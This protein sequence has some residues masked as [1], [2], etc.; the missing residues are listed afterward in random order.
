M[1]HGP[2]TGEYF[3][4]LHGKGV[5]YNWE[6]LTPVK[7]GR[8]YDSLIA[9]GF[10]YRSPDTVGAFYPCAQELLPLCRG[11]RRGGSAAIASLLVLNRL[12]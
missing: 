10:P 11:I 3:S 5:W 9:T 12:T 6:K 4:A 7:P 1:V 2:F 8:L